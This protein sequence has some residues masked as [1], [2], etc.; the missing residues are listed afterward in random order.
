MQSSTPKVPAPIVPWT[1]MHKVACQA[2]HLPSQR[3]STSRTQEASTRGQEGTKYSSRVT[4][5]ISANPVFGWGEWGSAQRRGRTCP[6]RRSRNRVKL[7]LWPPPL[8]SLHPSTLSLLPSWG[9]GQPGGRENELRT[10]FFPH[11]LL[12]HRTTEP[13]QTGKEIRPLILPVRERRDFERGGACLE[14]LGKG[15]TSGDEDPSSSVVGQAL[16]HPSCSWP[17]HRA[18]SP[19]L[20]RT[21][22]CGRWKREKV[23]VL[24]RHKTH[25]LLKVWTILLVMRKEGLTTVR[26]CGANKLLLPRSMALTIIF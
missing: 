23:P 16:S 24:P 9:L 4:S 8:H 12:Y 2:L 15:V 7:G 26:V 3:L 11:S 6:R 1:I 5:T 17:P 10:D 13:G 20:Q 22:S 14:P 18:C 21:V 25:G 19:R